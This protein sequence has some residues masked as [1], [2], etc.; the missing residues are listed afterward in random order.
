MP[1]AERKEGLTLGSALHSTRA[2]MGTVC[3]HTIEWIGGQMGNAC[4]DKD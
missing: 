4:L 1:Y 2:R 3:I